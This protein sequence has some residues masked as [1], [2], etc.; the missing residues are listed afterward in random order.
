V[1]HSLPDLEEVFRQLIN[2]QDYEV[3]HDVP[4]QRSGCAFALAGGDII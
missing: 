4:L 3:P 1:T 2:L